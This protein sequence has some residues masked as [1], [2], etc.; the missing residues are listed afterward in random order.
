[1]GLHHL[2]EE[3]PPGG[4]QT[5]QACTVG[6]SEGEA[7]AGLDLQEHLRPREVAVHLLDVLGSLDEREH[8]P[9]K[10]LLPHRRQVGVVG[11]GEGSFDL[12][13]AVGDVDR[14]PRANHAAR[15]L[16]EEGSVRRNRD[17]RSDVHVPPGAWAQS[18]SVEPQKVQT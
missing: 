16:L 3:V 11:F 18:S 12:E 15:A 4:H 9:P 13:G 7:A 14:L 17:D 2:D 8:H 10:P 5:P 1:V 6:P